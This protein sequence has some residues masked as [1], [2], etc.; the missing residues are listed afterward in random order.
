MAIWPTVCSRALRVLKID[1]H[2]HTAD[3][4]ADHIAYST[5]ELIDRAAALRYDAVAITLHDR[6]LDLAPYQTY[7]AERGIT[8]IRGIERTIGGKHVLLLNFSDAA[9]EVASF[10]DLADLRACE[11]GLVV[12]PHPFFPGPA[13][14]GAL[15]RH[16]HLFDAVEWNAMF[17]R[18]L[19]FNRRAERWAAQHGKPMVGNG[20]VHRLYQ[21]GTCYSLVDAEPTPDSICE[22]IRHGRVRVEARPLSTLRAASTIADLF[23][24]D[25]LARWLSGAT[26]RRAPEAEPAL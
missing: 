18:T 26:V 20:D 24:T 1:L 17:T 16:A 11:R 19:N 6:Q 2:I 23:G 10:A 13:L 15:E 21:L 5:R 3:D 25:V 12:A 22:A 8:L 9:E 4:P 7:A 14:Q